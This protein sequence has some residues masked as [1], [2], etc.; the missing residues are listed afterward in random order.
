MEHV[1]IRVRSNISKFSLSAEAETT[2]K[3]PRGKGERGAGMREKEGNKEGDVTNSSW[4]ER[5]GGKTS[6]PEPG[7]SLRTSS[8]ISTFCLGHPL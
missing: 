5:E 7:E 8:Q 3:A 6:G 2:A 1:P 4:S